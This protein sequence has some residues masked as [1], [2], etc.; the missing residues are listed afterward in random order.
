MS[1]KPWLIKG[2]VFLLVLLLTACQQ[3]DTP[4]PTTAPRIPTITPT[5][6]PTSTPSLMPIAGTLPPTSD[7]NQPTWTPT[8]TSTRPASA[9]PRPD[10]T[11][12]RTPTPATLSSSAESLP[13]GTV[14]LNLLAA[15]LTQANDLNVEFAIEPDVMTLTFEIPNAFLGQATQIQAL[16]ET[17]LDETQ[18]Q[19]TLTLRDFSARGP[20]VTRQQV[21]D[22]IAEIA[23]FLNAYLRSEFTEAIQQETDAKILNISL[24]ANFLVVDVVTQ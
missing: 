15:D 4:L 11:P 24:K 2:I 7:V 18:N 1:L 21:Q 20:Q 14:R 5:P 3:E 9:T 13:D 22:K 6:R 12:T 8:L 17:D 16:V 10:H 19:L 23:T